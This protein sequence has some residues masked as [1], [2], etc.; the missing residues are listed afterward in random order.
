MSYSL[1]WLPS[2]L[3]TA[4]LKV[5]PV[6]GWETRGHGDMGPIR[7][8]MCHHTAGP[9]KGNMPSLGTLIKGRADL[10]G[11][12]S[13]LGLGRDGTY[14]VIAAGRCWHAGKGRWQD[15]VNGNSHFIAIEAENAGTPADPWPEIQLRAYEAG[16]AALLKHVRCSLEACVGHKEYALPVGRKPDPWFDMAQFRANVAT[17]LG[18]PALGASPVVPQIP[19]VEPSPPPDRPARATL[20]RGSRTADVE[21]VQVSVGAAATGYFDAATE[22][23]VREFQRAHGLVPD[24]IVGPKTW[25]VIDAL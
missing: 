4:G 16:V 11:P 8:V 19:A 24:G 2:V 7:G 14:Y 5:A 18:L 1:S 21:L 3:Q 23:S 12:L 6:D 15:T 13:H 22:A 20:R 17:L 9:A 10:P 25:R